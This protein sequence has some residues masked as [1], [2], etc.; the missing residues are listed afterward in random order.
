MEKKKRKVHSLEEML[1]AIELYET[2]VGSGSIS[3]TYG[4]HSSSVRRWVRQYHLHG[5]SGLKRSSMP[6][7]T[8]ELRIQVVEYVLNNCVTLESAASHYNVSVMAV[9][10][11]MERFREE[12]YA[13]FTEKP[14]GRPPN[15]MGRPKKKLPETELERLREEN[16]Q[17]KAQVAFLKK[18]KALVEERVARE[19]GKLPTPSKD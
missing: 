6:Q 10:R 5:V 19:S 2:G 11:W 12:G 9:T 18:L 7:Y 4:Y 14:F 17:L 8:D 3:R 13:S 16:L 1:Q 15:V